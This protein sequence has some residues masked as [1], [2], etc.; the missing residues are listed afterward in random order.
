VALSD[1]I[2]KLMKS[3]ELKENPLK[4]MV[5]AVSVGIVKGIPMLDLCYEED[6]QA[7]LDMNVVMTDKNEFIEIQG[8][9]EAAPFSRDVLD[10][11]LRLAKKGI[12]ELHEFQKQA[13][14]A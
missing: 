5:A 12:D 6:S 3:G 11:M 14:N 13:L 9:G 2:D 10:E 8:T 1:A 7:D 4:S